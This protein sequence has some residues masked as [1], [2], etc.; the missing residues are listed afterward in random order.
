VWRGEHGQ[1]F[2]VDPA[3]LRAA[4]PELAEVATG[5]HGTL[6]RLR[7]VLT[8]AGPCWGH[9]EAGAAFAHGYLPASDQAEQAFQRLAAV[10]EAFG[11]DLVTVADRSAETDQR[12]GARFR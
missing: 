12:A 9:D 10:L 1:S 2:S 4:A 5:L 11:A 6:A 3:A 7:G 8:D